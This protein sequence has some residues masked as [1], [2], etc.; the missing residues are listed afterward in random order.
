MYCMPLYYCVQPQRV[1]VLVCCF[2]FCSEFLDSKSFL[3]HILKRNIDIEEELTRKAYSVL[4]I[5]TLHIHVYKHY[6]SLYYLY[7]QECFTRIFH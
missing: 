2:R 5:S 4:Y 3:K 6:M 7:V 1:D